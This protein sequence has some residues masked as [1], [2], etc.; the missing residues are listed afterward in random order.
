MRALH[1]TDLLHYA[2]FAQS[3]AQRIKNKTTER[4]EYH[5]AR[6]NLSFLFVSS[7]PSVVWKILAAAFDCAKHFHL[8]T[9]S[10][11]PV[12]IVVLYFSFFPCHSVPAQPNIIF[13]LAD[14]LGTLDTNIETL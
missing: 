12:F 13:I 2:I 4:T 5:R 10:T 6:S 1:I 11:I 3:L 7:V 9:F 14:D 8:K